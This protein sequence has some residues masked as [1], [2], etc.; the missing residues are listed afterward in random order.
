MKPFLTYKFCSSIGYKWC[1]L[2]RHQCTRH[3]EYVASIYSNHT[4]KKKIHS[5]FYYLFFILKLFIYVFFYHESSCIYFYCIPYI[6]TCNSVVKFVYKYA[7]VY[8][9]CCTQNPFLI[10][11]LWSSLHIILIISIDLNQKKTDYC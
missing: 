6:K 9:I 5:Y 8:G 2:F 11:F 10:T 3:F 1:F 4:F 7:R